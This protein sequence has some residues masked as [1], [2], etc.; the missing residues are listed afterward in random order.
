MTVLIRNRYE[1]KLDKRFE[2]KT[3]DHRDR[4]GEAG[5]WPSQFST[6]AV[7][8]QFSFDPM[9]DSYEGR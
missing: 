1:H 5:C 9:E 7:K 8:C 3:Q 4:G 2:E 6:V